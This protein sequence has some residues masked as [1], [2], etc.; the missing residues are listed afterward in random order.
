M[1]ATQ[2]ICPSRAALRVWALAGLLFG[3]PALGQEITHVQIR[4]FDGAPG[5][6]QTYK[7]LDEFDVIFHYSVTGT[8]PTGSPRPKANITIGGN[9]RESQP[10]LTDRTR[11][12]CRYRITNTDLDDDGITIPT[13][14]LTGGPNLPDRELAAVETFDRHKVDG[15][16]V[17]IDSFV[18]TSSPGDDGAYRACPRGGNPLCDDGVIL[19][20]I[21]L[22]EAAQSVGHFAPQLAGTQPMT[23]L[24]SSYPTRILNYR[25]VV[26]PSEN[27]PSLK[28]V[29][30]TGMDDVR[31]AAGNA[32]VEKDG[33]AGTRVPVTASDV[34]LSYTGSPS[35]QRID[36][37]GPSVVDIRLASLKRTFNAADE[38]VDVVV[39]F[40]EA[41]TTPETGQ[42]PLL[43]L[44]VDG[45]SDSEKRIPSVAGQTGYELIFRWDR[46]ADADPLDGTLSIPS[47]GLVLTPDRTATPA[48][49]LITDEAGNDASNTDKSYDLK[50]R[51]DA[52][53]P[54]VKSVTIGS[55]S[56][57]KVGSNLTFTVAFDEAVSVSGGSPTLSFTLADSGLTAPFYRQQSTT[58][59]QFRYTLTSAATET[60]EASVT[61]ISDD[62]NSITD[63]AGNIAD[64]S[65]SGLTLPTR[66]IS[67]ATTTDDTTPPSCRSASPHRKLYGAG[68]TITIIVSC[69]EDVTVTSATYSFTIGGVRRVTGEGTAS[70]SRISFDYAVDA[71]DTG[72]V[73]SGRIVLGGSADITDGSA[74]PIARSTPTTGD[75]YVPTSLS[76]ATVDTSP[77]EITRFRF[78]SSP[79]TLDPD[80]GHMYYG[81]GELIEME[82]DFN[83]DVVLTGSDRPTLTL[84]DIMDCSADP[85]T[86]RDPAASA[87]HFAGG[88]GGTATRSMTF[89]YRVLATDYAPNGISIG[90]DALTYPDTMLEDKA[91]ND[92]APETALTA[93]VRTLDGEHPVDG[94]LIP[95]A[96]EEDETETDPDETEPE[97]TQGTVSPV[98]TARV[99]T[100]PRSAGLYQSGDPLRI[101]IPMSPQVSFTNAPQ[102]TLAFEGGRTRTV[103]ANEAP[104]A[105]RYFSMLTFD[106]RVQNGD[107]ALDGISATLAVS[108]GFSVRDGSAVRFNGSVS[109]Q[110]PV[111]VDAKAP[112]LESVEIA[113]N[114]GTDRTYKAGDDIDVELEFSEPVTASGRPSLPIMVGNE[115]VSASLVSSSSNTTHVFRYEVETGDSDD[116]GISI[117]A[118]RN[119]TLG[120]TF[121]DA[122]G[123]EANTSHQALADNRNHLVDTQAPAVTRITLGAGQVYGEGDLITAIVTFDSAVVSSSATLEIIV[124]SSTQTARYARGTGTNAL[125]FT[126]PVRAGDQGAVSVAAD[127]LKGVADAAGNPADANSAMSFPG[128]TVDT[129]APM[130][131]E[132]SF[133]SMP[134]TGD[135]YASGETVTVQVTFDDTVTVTGSPWMYLT[136][137]NLRP[138]AT[139]AEGSGSSTLTFDYVV[140]EDDLDE[141]GISIAANQLQAAGSATIT[142][143]NRVPASLDHPARPD[144]AQHKVDAVA[145]RITGIAI[146]STPATGDAYVVGERIEV[147]VTFDED[148]AVSGT[149]TLALTVGAEQ[150]NAFCTRGRASETLACGYRVAQGD[151]DDDG[152]S[153]AEG[154]L[155]GG[156]ITDLPGNAGERAHGSLPDD[157]NHKVL[158]PPT[159]LAAFPSLSLTAGGHA[160]TMDLD[161]YFSGSRL[162]FSASSSNETVAETQV[163]ESTLTVRSKA[164]GEA[165]I[166]VTAT[167]PSGRAEGSF[168]V[169]VTTDPVEKAA[170][171][172]AVAAV[173]RSMLASTTS[174][175]G[176]RFRL[177]AATAQ[178]TLGGRSIGISRLSKEATAR[179]FERA[180]PLADQLAGNAWARERHGLASALTA[181]RL[182]TGSAFNMPL[183]A[184][185]GLGNTSFAIWGAGDL[186][187]FEGEPDRSAYEGS[188]TSGHIGIDARGEGWLAGLAVS[189]SG[190]STDYDFAGNVQGRGTL[191]TSVTGFH[192]YAK[193]DVDSAT[194]LWAVGGFGAGE[195]DLTRNHVGGQSQTSDLSMAMAA[196]GLK[197]ALSLV[198]AGG[199]V[200][201]RAD[202]GFL[203]LE[204]DAGM[205]AV[206]SLAA[207]VSR[208]RVG[209]EATW[210]GVATPFLEVSGRF[211][212]G[213][214][215]S[216]GGL[217]FAGGMRIAGAET[218]FGLEAK[219]RVLALHSGD[220]YRD[221]GVSVTASLAPGVAGRGMVLR[222]SPRWG[223]SA[224]ATDLFWD[225]VGS[226]VRDA[227][228][229]FRRDQGWGMDAFF[230]YGFD[231]KSVPGLVTP[232]GQ[233]DV[234]SDKDRRIRIGVRYAFSRGILS[235]TELEASAERADG[236]LYPAPE[237]RLL[238]T[239][240]ARF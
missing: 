19:A 100:R 112:E 96:S 4:G 80:D 49:A 113:S 165:S 107:Q 45:S 127:A 132:V 170:L 178:A 224:D 26:R 7:Y 173:G 124:G 69:N 22:S 94:S 101:E 77:P 140:R 23:L 50:G 103:R 161:T 109:F 134:A 110:T 60:V 151:A 223:G 162:V 211:D 203:T 147:T 83:E 48:P 129:A 128:H 38:M 14:A 29:A 230:G 61:T 78:T 156:T 84:G 42:Q 16:H 87:T 225:E 25:Y 6:D 210:Q 180:D 52:K 141:D 65:P 238:L 204:T 114:A 144:D 171:N 137:G 17:G 2:S 32:G 193:L 179:F 46:S 142:D 28:L 234:A 177:D 18:I 136:V 63:S 21:T 70:G 146:S 68:S 37:R 155:S 122:A 130:V 182:L 220:G 99:T 9:E 197:R 8:V 158:P 72:T 89:R 120:G 125:T 59:L 12:V 88:I 97:Q 27:A 75:P 33:P 187:A 207:T 57:A 54:A 39:E 143:S 190:A 214:G 44:E 102:L 98:G 192:P 43:R 119:G 174:V 10:C 150:R 15:V 208:L 160:A 199:S 195:A 93:Y 91:G 85:C 92:L 154:E 121:E 166:T 11:L 104:A 237:A 74:N 219:G 218:G 222:L 217:E 206:D 34:L 67:F 1:G 66:N 232:F 226:P 202:A 138:S 20:T 56:N 30:L 62:N 51:I 81:E 90:A 86:T 126:Y 198:F 184:A 213:D 200:S 228:H 135:T 71:E 139:Y 175:I 24:D 201:L 115:K 235:A 73:S 116:N 145:P 111:R 189:R 47:S 153:V 131:T 176:S 216:G 35:P 212:G 157:P 106:D 183:N 181:Q 82:I 117:P 164:E 215:Q 191:E 185:G 36:N 79:G 148:I 105:G 76:S 167:N 31:D 233:A 169:T 13:A 152:V 3:L 64:L 5:V 58:Q 123:N 240:Q 188:M 95:G 194:E 172:D 118:L 239:G 209:L 53:P 168:D 231:L 133:A 221:S 40:D 229:G 55:L 205:Q 149:P 196:G 186:Q 163:A 159:A 236:W 41:V 227:R 108:G